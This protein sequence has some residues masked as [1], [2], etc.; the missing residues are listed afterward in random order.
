MR[1]ENDFS[2]LIRDYIRISQYSSYLSLNCL[3]NV[4]IFFVM[5]NSGDLL[6]ANRGTNLSI[7]KDF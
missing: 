6:S 2:I 4:L 1:I 7:W 3:N 5:P